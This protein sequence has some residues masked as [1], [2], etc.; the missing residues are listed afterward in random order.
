MLSDL[1][2]TEA[3]MDIDNLNVHQ[4]AHSNPI[5]SVQPIRTLYSNKIT[6]YN[7]W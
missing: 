6:G 7:V 2:N 1:L 5:G 4:F 3:R